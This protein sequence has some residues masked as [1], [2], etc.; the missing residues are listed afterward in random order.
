VPRAW[1]ATI[2][3]LLAATALF[4]AFGPSGS[5]TDQGPGIT[6]APGYGELPLAFEPSR[7][8]T[9][10]D[11]IARSSSGTAL[12]SSSGAELTLGHGV[13]ASTV[14]L[15]VVGGA[16]HEPA[17]LDRLPGVVN[18]LRGDDATRWQTHIPTFE[19]VR[20][21]AVYP[22]VDLDWHGT[23]QRLEYDFRVAPGADPSPIAMRVAGADRV[24]LERNGDLVVA[25]GG[26]RVRQSAPVAYQGEGS[27][28]TP[29]DARFE[30]R[31]NTV[32]FSLGDYDR[33]RTLVIDPVVLDYSTYLG[34]S[35]ADRANGIAVDSG[36]AAYLTG[37]TLSTDFN[38]AG[39]VEPATGQG[40]VFVTK[41]NAAGNAIVYSTYLG[42]EGDDT[43]NGIAVDATGAYVV[44]TTES[45]D[46]NT[47]NPA[48]SDTDAGL[49][50][51]FVAKL[52]PAGDGLVYS[53]YLGGGGTFAD[54]GSNSG[55]VSTGEEVFRKKAG[56]ADEGVAIAID[57]SGAAYVAGNTHAKSSDQ[58]G[59]ATAGFP[60]KGQ[61]ESDTNETQEN[62]GTSGGPNPSTMTSD[63]F[64]T[65][66]APAGNELVYST[67]IG[68]DSGEG[69]TA[70]AVDSA[71]A[72]YVA[73][74]TNSTDFDTTGG[75][76]EGPSGGGFDDREGS[77]DFDAFV[78]KLTPAGNGLAYSTYLGG[79]D[80]D[81]AHAIAVDS[82]GAAYV[83]G[84]T[85]SS[86]FG[87]GDQTNTVEGDSPGPD[88]FV[89]KLNPAGGALE[90]STYLGGGLADAANG[91]AV[92]ST[93]RALI[94]G[95]TSSRDFDQASELEGDG[96]L[97]DAFVSSLTPA[98][99]L[100]CSTY[101]GGEGSDYGNAI[102][103]DSSGAAYVVGSTE[104]SDF[105]TAGPVEADSAG[106]DAF[107]SKL[108]LTEPCEKRQSAGAAPARDQ[109]EVYVVVLDGLR[110]REVTP[111]QTPFIYLLKESGT[112]YEQARAV[113][114]AE[115]LPN[116]AAMMTGVLP[117][118]S[119]LLGN[120]YW[121]RNSGQARTT[122]P[123]YGTGSGSN[124][125]MFDPT[126]LDVETLPTTLEESCDVSSAV[127]QSKGYL[128]YLFAGEPPNPDDEAWQR[129]ADYI[130]GAPESESYIRDPDDHTVD[131]AVMEEGFMPWMRSSAP[132]P[133]F[134]FLN[135]GD[136]DRSGH[137][138]ETGSTIPWT[139]GPDGI[140]IGDGTNVTAFRQAALSDTDAQV[141]LFVEE[142]KSREAWDNSIVIFT[143]D[144][145]MDWS[146]PEAIT[147]FH[148][149]RQ[150]PLPTTQTVA[151][152]PG[153]A[154]VV[155]GGG[156]TMYYL[157]PGADVEDIADT[158]KTV[159]G[160]E[161][162]ATRERIAGYPTLDDLGMEHPDTGDIIG[163]NAPGWRDGGYHSSTGNPIP[164]NHGHGVTQHSTLFVVGGHPALDENPESVTGPKVYSPRIGRYFSRP[165]GGPGN[166]S[167][168]PTV[169]RLFGVRAPEAGYDG[170][171]LSEAF[172]DWALKEHS[173]CQVSDLPVLDSTDVSVT[174]GDA[175]TTP[176]EVTVRLTKA[177]AAP[178]SVDYETFD[179][180]ATAP[181]DYDS[182][183]PATLTFAPGETQKTISVLVRGDTLDESD[184]SFG[185]RFSGQ[186]NAELGDRDATVTI[187]DDDET[188][189]GGPDIDGP[190]VDP[191]P[192]DPDE[193][194]GEPLPV[195]RCDG[196]LATITGTARS[197]RLKRRLVGTRRR[198]V[199]AALGGNDRVDGR[200]RADTICGGTGADSLFGGRGNDRVGG[201]TGRDRLFGGRGKDTLFGG[202]G[203]DRIY[204]V[205]GARD[206]IHCGRGFDVVHVGLL[207][208]VDRSC[209]RVKRS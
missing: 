119:G 15:R 55:A 65:K 107:A 124:H 92:D 56:A 186:S 145:G 178:V 168:A 184:E 132:S 157:N 182:Q 198:D 163:L 205:A 122:Q 61:F 5:S 53:T 86:D 59:M 192:L 197:D 35:D 11:F 112:W 190:G 33:S 191:D 77:A 175:G 136:I 76:I 150:G 32:S 34:G 13:R 87:A 167:V 171:P 120:D 40:D 20:Y 149:V 152:K 146:R 73:G 70:I 193:P 172:D 121:E 47:V 130:W 177:G 51:A 194:G 45:T 91:I 199:I 38:T 170:S 89:S 153:V 208:R 169:S 148:N 174:E 127:V 176:A 49:A 155:S 125:R 116:H 161:T 109:L 71:G 48:D 104:S 63:A 27:R 123:L 195:R 133:R 41:L 139:E 42:G 151:D 166:L 90:Y 181:G 21:A 114:L 162:V 138:D 18:D 94:T 144:H 26:E 67:Y 103:V 105:N 98:G 8:R 158:L 126:K 164:G 96:G 203:N 37:R 17:A 84:K 204:T 173:P 102:A 80:Y 100:A 147:G 156:T 117:E 131:A 44:G 36:G 200:G 24:H 50:D 79:T 60:V 137:V 75:K 78:S 129:R 31:G 128:W 29:V 209:E 113:Y 110:P 82:A 202:R 22:G 154:R 66:L 30:L 180:T 2:V 99:G 72:A 206:R 83:T 141:Q 179:R 64:V 135:L 95:T 115:T 69:A 46:F 12:I 142:L 106:S 3:L 108:S 16:G 93:G 207:D 189:A 81:A 52:N 88:A 85:D 97:E 188:A 43:G 187:V 7:G 6:Q 74:A 185:V 4:L 134:A 201:G 159:Q 165:D 25:A 54:G 101:L 183:G 57:S 10:A 143:S 58:S 14:D 23:Q 111:A 118:R 62:G 19:R 68:G 9:D 28:R 140:D 1:R 196:L 160:I 39:P